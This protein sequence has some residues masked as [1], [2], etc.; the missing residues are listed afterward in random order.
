MEYPTHFNDIIILCNN[1]YLS[2]EK[3]Y[4]NWISFF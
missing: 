2:L 3:T 4:S 1:H